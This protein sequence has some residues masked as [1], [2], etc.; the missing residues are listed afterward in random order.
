M[1]I[2]EKQFQE[3]L[4]KKNL[5]IPYIIKPTKEEIEEYGKN[6]RFHGEVKI[7]EICKS[8]FD[9]GDN[10]VTICGCCKIVYQ[11]P[12]CKSIN[13]NIIRKGELNKR[14]IPFLKELASENEI[15]KFYHFCDIYCSQSF[16][17]NL[18]YMRKSRS[19]SNL[20]YRAEHPEEAKKQFEDC[21]KAAEKWRKENP[22]EVRN[23]AM[24][25][26]KSML[27]WQEKHPEEAL[28]QKQEACKSMQNILEDLRENEEWSK[29]QA[30]IALENLE[31]A[32][33]VLDELWKDSEWAKWR[34]ELLNGNL[35]KAREV[36]INKIKEQISK[37]PIF[38]N[39]NSIDI[40]NIQKLIKNDICGAYV[41]KAKFK[42]YKG[43]ER[44]KDVFNLLTC[45]SKS[46]YSEIY[47]VLRVISQ[48]EIQN[49]N[50]SEDNPW[51]KAK[52]WYISNLYYDFEFILLT[53]VDGVSEKQALLTEAK[54]AIENDLFVEFLENENGNKTPNIEKHSYWSL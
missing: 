50:V 37:F 8:E 11:C 48:P 45:K 26:I 53:D 18:P 4:S 29:R 41:I 20:K 36:R 3:E 27:K 30:K 39:K 2:A 5:I 9:Y 52:W 16:R 28:I 1:D 40:N 25:G 6:F 19:E 33:A 7:C 17:G 43:T 24:I 47:W 38:I 14:K 21:R 32:N 46:I 42:S 12:Q 10:R 35:E 34:I 13:T 49:K 54:Y 23:L 44:E 22:E 15:F 31:K 51:T